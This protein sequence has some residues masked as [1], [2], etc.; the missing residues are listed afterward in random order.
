M[1]QAIKQTTADQV[2]RSSAVDNLSAAQRLSGIM[3]SKEV[4]DELREMYRE[5]FDTKEEIPRQR[6]QD[7][8]LTID[9]LC[10]AIREWMT[11]NEK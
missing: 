3:E 5:L 6:M 8:I 11:T 1:N 10:D 4:E 7:Y 9:L 2:S